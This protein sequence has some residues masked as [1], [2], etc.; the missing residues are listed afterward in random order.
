MLLDLRCLNATAAT[1]GG[2]GYAHQNAFNVLAFASGDES[3]DTVGTQIAALTAHSQLTAYTAATTNQQLAQ[4][5]MAQQQMM[6]Q[7]AAMSITPTPQQIMAPVITLSILSRAM[8][9][10][11]QPQLATGFQ[12][13]N[14]SPFGHRFGRC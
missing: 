12:Y 14:P 8:T 2:Q 1:L 13:N 10:M 3:V 6:S 4:L 11:Q 9:Q 7:L 5:Q